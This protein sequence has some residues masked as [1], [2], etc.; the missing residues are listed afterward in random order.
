MSKCGLCFYFLGK[1]SLENRNS[2]LS[3][4]EIKFT[5][6][7]ALSGITHIDF[8]DILNTTQIFFSLSGAIQFLVLEFY[9]KC[10]LRYTKSVTC[11]LGLKVFCSVRS[12]PKTT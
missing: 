2:G 4:T 11:A 7:C 3:K 6:L 12:A 1:G 10:Y 9:K 8:D 5:V